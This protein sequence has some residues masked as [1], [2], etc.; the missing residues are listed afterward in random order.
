MI[1]ANLLP[2]L[3]Y[4]QLTGVYN[5]YRGGDTAERTR[6]GN[7]FAVEC[8]ADI[9]SL[10]GAET[11][12][13]TVESSFTA[14]EGDTIVVS[15]QSSWTYYMQRGDT[16]SII[17]TEDRKTKIVYDEPEI[18]LRFPMHTGDSISGMYQGRGEYCESL[19]I[20]TCGIYKTK[21]RKAVTVILHDGDTISGVMQLSTE[22][23]ESSFYSP[24]D[25]TAVLHDSPSVAGVPLI[26]H[27]SIMSLTGSDDAAVRAVIH[28][29]YAPGYRYPILETH[30]RTLAR[31]GRTLYAR[32]WYFPPERQAW[33]NPDKDNETLRSLQ[34][35]PDESGAQSRK[36][37]YRISTDDSANAIKVDFS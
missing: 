34:N 9:I 35:T 14:G 12:G 3:A 30:R 7:E 18:W 20:R 8:D 5:M 15:D 26:P 21:A 10:R 28:R 16:L 11:D 33:L 29:Y 4:A 22:R 37:D 32:A 25:S 24:R 36:T 6:L 23:L 1:V 19:F 27:D 31:T 13:T 17:G 2:L